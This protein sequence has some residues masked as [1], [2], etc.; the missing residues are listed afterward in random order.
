MWPWLQDF[1]TGP[2]GKRYFEETNHRHCRR[3]VDLAPWLWGWPN[4]FLRRMHH[5]GTD[6]F[7]ADR[8]KPG[9][10]KGLDSTEDLKKLPPG[11]SGGI[12]TDRVAIIG[13]ALGRR[14]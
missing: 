1:P 4:R 13:P 8:L 14:R 6:V 7:V 3:P 12:W 2:V 5:V 11:Y 10:L 9:G